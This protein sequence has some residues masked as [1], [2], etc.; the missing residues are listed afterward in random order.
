MW[1]AMHLAPHLWFPFF[2]QHILQSF[3]KC[4]QSL[5]RVFKKHGGFFQ[6]VFLDASQGGHGGVALAQY[7]DTKVIAAQSSDATVAV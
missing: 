1:G 2:D 6:D 3:V 5:F 4:I 7:E